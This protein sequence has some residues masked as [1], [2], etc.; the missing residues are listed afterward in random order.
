MKDFEAME[1]QFHD[2][3][4]KNDVLQMRRELHRMR[5]IVSNLRFTRMMELL[6]KYENN[7]TAP[8]ELVG[9]NDELNDCLTEIYYV[10]KK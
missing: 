3:M 4:Q 7:E 8:I 10:L 6:D 9:L 2:A 5:P 1:L